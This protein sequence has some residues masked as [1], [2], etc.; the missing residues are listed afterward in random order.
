MMRVEELPDR[1][2]HGAVRIDEET[3]HEPPLGIE[4][5]RHDS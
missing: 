4:V 2:G 5:G 3:T 1:Q